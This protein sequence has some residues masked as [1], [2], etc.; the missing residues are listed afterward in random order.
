MTRKQ[1]DDLKIRLRR[2]SVI[3][4]AVLVA[5]IAA[6]TPAFAKP[7]NAAPAWRPQASE[8]LVKLPASYLEKSLERDF[9]KSELGKAIQANEEKIGLKMQT[10]TDLQGAMDQAEGEVQTELRHQFLA[11]KRQYL[12]LMVRRM[13]LGRKHL[14]TKRR[15]LERLQKRLGQKEASLTPARIKLIEAQEAS[16]RRFNASLTKV[17]VRLVAASAAPETRYA[18]EYARNFQAV[19]TL[20]RAIEEHPAKKDQVIDGRPMTKQ[21]YLRRMAAETEAETALLDRQESIL[22]YMAKLVALDATA[23]TEAIDVTGSVE[24]DGKKSPD[25]TSAVEFFVTR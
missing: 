19:E 16:R 10:L 15:L 13:S 14:E 25:V 4:A 5:A 23:L 11:E 24:G 22:G 9:S 18:R 2:P 3:L 12:D 7:D 17:E 8:R 1:T 6:Q 20:I 21:D